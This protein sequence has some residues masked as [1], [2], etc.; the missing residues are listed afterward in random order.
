MKVHAEVESD[1]FHSDICPN[2]CNFKNI[3]NEYREF[4]HD[5]LDEWLDKS[6]GTGGFYIKQEGYNFDLSK[7]V[8]YNKFEMIEKS[9]LYKLKKK[10]FESLKENRRLNGMF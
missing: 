8:D 4:L 10:L 7:V 1:F 3:N 9:L 2:G 5:C 6:K